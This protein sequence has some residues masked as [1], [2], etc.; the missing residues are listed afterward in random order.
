MDG[1]KSG[2]KLPMLA[3]L[4]LIAVVA[5]LGAA[6]WVAWS[7]DSGSAADNAAPHPAQPTQMPPPEGGA[8][9]ARPANAL[10]TGADGERG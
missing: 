1:S 9:P 7:E 8:V 2:G 3:V 5:L 4:A 6:I 10:A